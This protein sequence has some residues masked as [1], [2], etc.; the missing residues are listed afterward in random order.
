MRYSTRARELVL[1]SDRTIRGIKAEV[2]GGIATITARRGVILSCGGFAY[3]PDM[4]REHFGTDLP[5]FGP[6]GRNPGDGVEVAVR[7]GA[8]LWHM[9]GLSSAYGYQLPGS[10]A[11]WMSTLHAHSF[12]IVD[13]HGR[14]YMDETAAELHNAGLVMLTRNYVSGRFDRCPSFLIFDEAARL[15][16]PISTD[17]SGFKRSIPWSADN[18]DEVAKGWIRKGDS[19]FELAAALEL[20]QRASDALTGT[21]REYNNAA[22]SGGSDRFGRT[23]IE[24]LAEPLYGI[25]IS[26]SIVNTQGGPRRDEHARVIAVD[27]T[28]IP[29]LYSAGELGSMWAILY[30]GAGNLTEAL[31]FGRI[32][33]SKRSVVEPR[34]R[35]EPARRHG[36]CAVDAVVASA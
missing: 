26:P 13:Q 36:R 27:G 33:G 30:P 19:V 14:R 11:A 16:G 20:D 22:S 35:G 9:N 32:A 15:A 10:R 25:P 12:F 28:P 34:R 21:L 17:L 2:R 31:V 1:D 23:R 18:A 6:P 24:P 5:A 7:A 3:R 29:R 8:N 4:V